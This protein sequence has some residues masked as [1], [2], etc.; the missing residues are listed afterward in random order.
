LRRAG[1]PPRPHRSPAARFVRGKV[2]TP[3]NAPERLPPDTAATWRQQVRRALLPAALACLG[4]SGCASLWDDITS[5]DFEV[6][7]FWEKPDPLVVL[8]DSTD[9]DK[10]AKAFRAL[11]EP[12]QYGGTPQMQD[13]VVT[14][15]CTAVQTERTAWSRQ[16]AISALRTF[17]DPRATDGLVQAYYKA[18][19]F[20]PETAN[21]IR[22]QA[23][24]GLGEAAGD[25]PAV[26]ILARVYTEQ[27]GDKDLD[28]PA[29]KSPAQVVERRLAK[30]RR[31][32]LDLLVKVV[33]EPPVEGPEQDKTQK[34]QER[35]AA[36]RALGH[37]KQYDAT[38]TLVAVL[39]TE[40]DPSL[41]A[42]AHESL[43]LVTGKRF[44]EDGQVWDDFIRNARD[45][46]GIYGDPSFTDRIKDIVTVGWWW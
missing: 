38:E 7:S 30:A 45:K 6:R 34:M 25:S 27:P 12:A 3:L 22:C 8:R 42:G 18:S 10:R 29:P 1:L 40:K 35:I 16:A 21:I 32:A 23:L 28:V 33:K 39:K 5:R 20:P 4:L 19:D 36:A 43:Q 26:E 37:F 41:R 17:K 31:G 11:R 9:G 44:P 15:L 13:Q 14:I 2:R 46:N 24:A